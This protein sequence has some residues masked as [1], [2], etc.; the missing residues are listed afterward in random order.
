MTAPRSMAGWMR[1]MA[2]TV[3]AMCMQ[4]QLHWPDWQQSGFN[5]FDGMACSAAVD[6]S[7]SSAETG[8]TAVS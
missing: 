2:G 5:D 3:N 7:L 6:L 4:A 8:S 1:A